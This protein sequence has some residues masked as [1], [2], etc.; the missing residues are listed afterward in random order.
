MW[1]VRPAI[2]G[3]IRGDGAHGAIVGWLAD[4]WPVIA[5]AFFTAI[6]A[7]RIYDILLGGPVVQGAGALSV[8]LAAARLPRN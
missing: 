8:L 1:R 4:L 2:A 6:V 3:L 5:T 7:A